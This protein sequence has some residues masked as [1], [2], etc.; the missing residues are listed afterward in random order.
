M[1]RATQRLDKV[2]GH[3]G[4]ASR[5]ELK[6]MARQGRITVNGVPVKDSGAAVAPETDRIEV[7]GVPVRYR[8][9]VYIMLHKP[10]GVVSATEDTR[11]RTVMDLLD[12]AFLAFKPFP[13]GRLDKDTEGLLLLTS[14]GQLAHSLL[15][16]KKHVPKTYRAEVLGSVDGDD[17]AAFRQ[18]VQLDDG[19]VTMPAEL[20]VLQ[21]AAANPGGEAVSSVEL[22][23]CEGKFHQ[24]KRMFASR[25]KKVVYLKRIR[26]GPLELD[27]ELPIGRYREL[28]EAELQLL[29]G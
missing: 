13:V 12:A 8:E 24:V 26:M 20:E 23:I 27:P 3:V 11:D 18:G 6:R 2:L 16:P 17:V 5:S 15:S 28:D 19:Y 22:T 29:K 1:K 10:Q 14:D 9:H 7:D 25:N 21:V 4:V